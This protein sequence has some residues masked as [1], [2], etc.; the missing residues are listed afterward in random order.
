MAQILL[1]FSFFKN[2]IY[3]VVLDDLLSFA[4]LTAE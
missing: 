1:I 4:Y 3:L 2:H